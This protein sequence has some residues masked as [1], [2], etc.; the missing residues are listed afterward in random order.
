M[1]VHIHA[2]WSV[3]EWFETFTNEH[4]NKLESFYA[5]IERADIYLKNDEGDPK[6]GKTVEI[7]LAVPK[8]D[9]FALAQADQIEVAFTQAVAKIKRQLIKHKALLNKH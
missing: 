9:L 2:P 1:K 7:R 3:N 6:R 5:R 8:N 4:M